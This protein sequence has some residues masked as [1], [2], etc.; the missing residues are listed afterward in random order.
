MTEPT[1]P[2]PEKKVTVADP[3]DV[4]SKP[5]DPET[6]GSPPDSIGVYDRPERG[7]SPVWIVLLVILLIIVGYFVIQYFV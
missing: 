5:V 6:K 7:I 4:E 2:I 1:D 3:S